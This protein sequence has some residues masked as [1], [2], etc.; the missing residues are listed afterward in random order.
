MKKF[1]AKEH[2]WTYLHSQGRWWYR[3]CR[4]D[5]W[6]I[7]STHV[8]SGLSMC[9]A[10]SIHG[11]K[12]LCCRWKGM[13]MSPSRRPSRL[14]HLSPA[15]LQILKKWSFWWCP[16]DSAWNVPFWAVT[17]RGQKVTLLATWHSYILCTILTLCT[18]KGVVEPLT[19][20]NSRIKRHS[21]ELLEN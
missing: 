6:Q 17:I 5:R 20:L 9:R 1:N 10:C 8:G 16:K 4:K 12:S 7:E 21:L 18:Q 19:H 2:S 3:N 13:P 15:V 14:P 11:S